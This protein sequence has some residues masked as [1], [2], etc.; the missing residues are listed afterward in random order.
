MAR[1]VKQS[2]NESEDLEQFINEYL[3]FLEQKED[4]EFTAD[5]EAVRI[6]EKPDKRIFYVKE[7]NVC[8]IGFVQRLGV[9]PSCG[10]AA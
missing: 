4:D 5:P 2:K 9:K 10:L 8:R 3:D 6:I 7:K 1:R